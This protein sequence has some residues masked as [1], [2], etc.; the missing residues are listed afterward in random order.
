MT[1]QTPAWGRPEVLAVADAAYAE[2]VRVGKD[3]PL[4]ELDYTQGYRD[5]WTE[6]WAAGAQLDEAEYRRGYDDAKAEFP[7]D[8]IPPAF[9]NPKMLRET[10]CLA[11]YVV[12]HTSGTRI[13]QHVERLGQ[14]I[15]LCDVLRPLGIDGKHGNRHAN[16]GWRHRWNRIASC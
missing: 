7:D 11:Q 12:S 13:P 2:G 1:D 8:P 9:S 6:A 16:K 4:A 3:S 5:G 15:A 14:M 10:L